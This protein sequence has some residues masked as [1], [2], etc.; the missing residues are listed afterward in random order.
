ME[1]RSAV[2]KLSFR[3]VASNLAVLP[4][5]HMEHRIRVLVAKPGLD[6]GPAQQYQIEKQARRDNSV[7]ERSLER[8]KH[9]AEG[10]EHTMPFILDAVRVY[11]TV[12]A[13]LSGRFSVPTPRLQCFEPREFLL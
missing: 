8:L 13:T 9:A 11:A 1:Q 3:G 6:D 4:S 12:G 5:N 10:D 2:R 7:V